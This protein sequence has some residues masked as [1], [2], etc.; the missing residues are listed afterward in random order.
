MGWRFRKIF[1]SGP[2]RWTWTKKGLG[3]SIGLPGLRY[4]VSPNGSRYISF[5][6]PGTGL[7]FIKYLDKNK[8]ASPSSTSPVSQT[9]PPTPVQ[10]TSQPSS[11]SQKAVTKPEP[12]WK[13]KHISDWKG[14][15]ED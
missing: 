9:S 11:S 3:W 13:Q 10:S 2:F 14:P 8:K 12:W 15:K 4:G 1:Q 6:I 5:G 7:Y